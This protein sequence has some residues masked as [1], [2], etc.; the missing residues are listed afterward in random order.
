MHLVH[1][2][3]SYP[4]TEGLWDIKNID[5]KLEA[6]KA[7]GQDPEQAISGQLQILKVLLKRKK[8]LVSAKATMQHKINI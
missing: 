5:Q 2:T 4:L 7:D 3:Y 1:D 8:P 6:I